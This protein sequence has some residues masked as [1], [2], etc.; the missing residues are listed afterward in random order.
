M[1]KQRLNMYSISRN[2]NGPNLP[3]ERTQSY[4]GG[5]VCVYV[6]MCVYMSMYICVHMWGWGD[7]EHTKSSPQPLAYGRP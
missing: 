6:Y 4:F 5:S 7:T 2:I 3:S 1:T